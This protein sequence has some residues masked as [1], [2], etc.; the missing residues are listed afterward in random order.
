LF[1]IS[2]RELRVVLGREIKPFYADTPEEAFSEFDDN[3]HDVLTF[4]LTSSNIIVFDSYNKES[5]AH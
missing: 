4:D 5:S 2:P 1:V 3:N